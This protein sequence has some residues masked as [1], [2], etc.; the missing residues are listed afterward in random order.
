MDGCDDSVSTVTMGET[1]PSKKRTT[2]TN[3]S[4]KSSSASSTHRISGDTS[5]A[6]SID[7]RVTEMER[8]LQGFSCQMSSMVEMMREMRD[9]KV[10][11]SN[12]GGDKSSAGASL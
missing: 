10:K 12:T 4:Y 7:T 11:E 8:Q 9:M 2:P 5:Q 3:K 1:K 6:N